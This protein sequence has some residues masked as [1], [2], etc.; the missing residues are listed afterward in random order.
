MSFRWYHRCDFFG[1]LHV[2]RGLPLAIIRL[3]CYSELRFREVF[4]EGSGTAVL[5]GLIFNYDAWLKMLPEQSAHHTPVVSVL[6]ER[7]VSC[8]PNP[9]F[10]MGYLAEVGVSQVPTYNCETTE[11]GLSE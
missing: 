7:E 11:T 1:K 6:F 3:F 10:T 2:D 5:Y 8:P 4:Q 9:T